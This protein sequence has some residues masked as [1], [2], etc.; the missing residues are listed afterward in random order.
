MKTYPILSLFLLLLSH[1]PA[2]ATKLQDFPPSKQIIDL[3]DNSI[4]PMCNPDLAKNALAL[5][6]DS[7][8][9]NPA[10][11]SNSAATLLILNDTNKIFVKL[12]QAANVYCAKAKEIEGLKIELGFD[13]PP[14]EQKARWSQL[15]RINEKAG[16]AKVNIDNFEMNL[17]ESI[18]NTKQK[19]L[20]YVDKSNDFSSVDKTNI[21]QGI[22]ELYSFNR[23][24]ME[25]KSGFDVF[26][27]AAR[28]EMPLAQERLSQS[29]KDVENEVPWW[30]LF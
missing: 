8:K 23:R 11:K 3:R 10:W 27:M 18:N 4:S 17:R 7:L 14:M 6:I 22:E 1:A 2:E 25:A 21:Q 16:I 13:D 26:I 19:L 9:S 28:K 30:F 24:S 29:E 15:K 5:A 12:Q 20:S